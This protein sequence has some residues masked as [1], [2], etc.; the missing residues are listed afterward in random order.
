MAAFANRGKKSTFF[1]LLGVSACAGLTELRAAFRRCALAAHP[2]K[3]GSNEAFQEVFRAF[4]VLSDVNQRQKYEQSLLRADAA[5]A[6]SQAQPRKRRRQ[7][8]DG[9]SNNNNNNNN[10]NKNNDNNNSDNSNKKNGSEEDQITKGQ[11]SSRLN[12][13]FVLLEELSPGNRRRVV[14]ECFTQE[15]RLDLAAW[16]AR[17]KDATRSDHSQE[18]LKSETIGC[19]T[20]PHDAATGSACKDGI[21]DCVETGDLREDSSSSDSDADY[22]CAICDAS[23]CVGVEQGGNMHHGGAAGRLPTRVTVCKG[24]R[25]NGSGYHAMASFNFAILFSKTTQDLAKALDWLA[26]LTAVSSRSR[27][28]LRQ[29]PELNFKKVVQGVFFDYQEDITTVGFSV[30]FRFYKKRWIGS[31]VMATPITHSLEEADAAIRRFAPLQSKT[32]WRNAP[33]VGQYSLRQ[34]W[35][36]FKQVFLEVCEALGKCRQA[37]AARLEALEA[38]RSLQREA[39]IEGRIQLLLSNWSRS[40]ARRRAQEAREAARAAARSKRDHWKETRAKMRHELTCGM[41][42]ILGESGGEQ[43]QQQQ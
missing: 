18:A 1:D 4:E 29:H 6:S 13:L 23:A 42:D 24:I 7:G 43:Q 12:Q 14:S 32:H 10:N 26:I 41:A 20:G 9:Y 21:A 33:K 8:G 19:S 27:Q 15:Q 16:A 31:S 2:D 39:E 17:Q 30:H 5:D 37:E 28:I 25:R 35:Q 40:T 36:L 22:P 34:R 3:G 11:D 38:A